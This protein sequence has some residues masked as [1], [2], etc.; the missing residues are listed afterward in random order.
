MNEKPTSITAVQEL[1]RSANGPILARG[2]GSKPALSD[3][4]NGTTA[5]ATGGLHGILAYEPAEYTFTALAGTA[6][7]EVVAALAE[8][9]QYLPFDPLLVA[10]GATLGGTVAANSAGSGRF[11]YGG[12]R[13]FILGI[14]FVDGRGQLVRSGGKVVKNAAGFDLPKFFVGSLGRYG[15]LVELT[16]KVFPRPQGYQTLQV[17][18]P[19]LAAALQATFRLAQTS[20]E[21]DAVDLLPEEGGCTLL[22]RLGGLAAVLPERVARLSQFLQAE[23]AATETVVLTEEA[24]TRLWQEANSLSWAPPGA[25]LVKIPLAPKQTPALD[26]QLDSWR[27]RYSCAANVA[28]VAAPDTA[29]L[30]QILCDLG[31]AGLLLSGPSADGPVADPILGHPIMGHPILGQ[32]RGLALAQRVKQ[33]LD[34]HAVFGTAV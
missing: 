25:A 19:D 30:H 7:V 32:R 28:W 3:P 2:G 16:F 8:N 20:L 5:V 14:A 21:M 17:A 31:L 24:D 26:K 10:A 13:D 15:L 1:I 33:A 6:V 22:L 18:Y 12:V 11:R 34:P 29:V 27:R 23:T 9:G 4:Q